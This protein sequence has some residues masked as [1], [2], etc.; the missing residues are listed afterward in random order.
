MK[1]IK[2]S[3][4]GLIAILVLLAATVPSQPASAISNNNVPCT[5][6]TGCIKREKGSDAQW[7]ADSWYK[8]TCRDHKPGSQDWIVNYKVDNNEWKNA[9]Q[10]KVR[11]YAA[12]WSKARWW[13]WT[14]KLQVEK[15]ALSSGGGI[16]L[17]MSGVLSENDVKGTYLWR[18]P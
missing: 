11:F 5:L 15:N 8:G 9:D 10:S 7:W 13:K 14:G 4:L 18:K 17:C 3:T 16:T 2:Y 1:T 12:N 6:P